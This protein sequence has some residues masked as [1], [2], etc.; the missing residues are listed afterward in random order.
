MAVVQFYKKNGGS[1]AYDENNYIYKMR[2]STKAKDQTITKY[3][4][5][6]K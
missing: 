4:S 6:V 2:N 1:R 5:C 3:Y